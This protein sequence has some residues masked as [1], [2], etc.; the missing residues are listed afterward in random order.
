[1][2]NAWLR[3]ITTG[4]IALLVL[5]M[6]APGLAAQTA[7]ELSFLRALGDH[8]QVPAEE[9]EI[10][11]EWQ[12][13]ISEIPVAL[14]IADRAGIS[15]D[16]LVASRSNGRAWAALAARYGLDAGFFH[17]EFDTPPEPVASL[18]EEL[19]ARPRERWSEVTVDDAQAVFLVN[20]RFLAE[21]VDLP[22]ADAAAALR[23]HTSP[24]EAL[25][26]ISP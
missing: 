23:E 16:A 1:M 19:G 13:P 8:Y 4:G 26:A 20:V 17:V 5:G 24:A 25:R 21:Y 10:L 3:R 22:P 12:I 9:V 14:A 7:P 15:P 2:T 18:Y 11:A 6:L